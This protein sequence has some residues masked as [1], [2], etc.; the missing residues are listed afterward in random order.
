MFN[1]KKL[2]ISISAVLFCSMLVATCVAQANRP[3]SAN[4]I[5]ATV[6]GQPIFEQDLA[7]ELGSKLLQLHNQQYQVE[8][9]AL[10]EVIQ[11]RVLEAE[12]KRRGISVDKL[13][14]EEVDSK[15]SEPSEAEVRGY[16]L[17]VRSEINKPFEDVKSQ[18][19]KAVKML[20]V[21]EARQDYANSL[22]AKNEVVVLLSPPKVEVAFDPSRVLGNPKAPITIVEFSDFQCPYCLKA[23]ATLKDLLVKYDGK[24]RLSYRDFPM[25][26]LHPRAQRAAEAARCAAEQGKFWEFHDALFADPSKLDDA[27]L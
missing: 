8:S 2:C 17:A 5:V 1:L 15:I 14:E 24:V 22:R 27:G 4:G 26:T 23:E 18:L 16:Y 11:R 19:Q 13:Q 10:D 21:A 12:A 9:K 25:R 6:N 20:K 7:P 3:S